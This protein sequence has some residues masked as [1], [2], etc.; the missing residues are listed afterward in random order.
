M[1]SRFK[2]H[3]IVSRTCRC[4]GLAMGDSA[5]QISCILCR[6]EIRTDHD[7]NI[8][9]TAFRQL[10]RGDFFPYF[11]DRLYR[12][13]LPDWHLD[14][15]LL[16]IRCQKV[17]RRYPKML[18]RHHPLSVPHGGIYFRSA[19]KR[20]NP[21]LQTISFCRN[22]NIIVACIYYNHV[23]SP[24]SSTKDRYC[25][26]FIACQVKCSQQIQ[27]FR[28]GS[29]IQEGTGKPQ[30]TPVQ[31]VV[32]ER[33]LTRQ[34]PHPIAAILALVELMEASTGKLP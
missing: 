29:R 23:C 6:R 15:I 17:V 25:W 30:R 28:R 20:V 4:A 19:F 1:I 26:T 5:S 34:V 16:D 31:R 24:S 32:I 3:S 11:L 33:Q 27:R 14:W 9:P 18:H 2:T 7:S 22:H 13:D 10:Q 8:I 21:T 12:C